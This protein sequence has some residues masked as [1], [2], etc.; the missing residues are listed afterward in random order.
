VSDHD[1]DRYYS[2]LPWQTVNWL[3][4]N[5]ISY[6]SICDQSGCESSQ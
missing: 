2:K 6:Q 4:S 5:A 1:N 3:Y